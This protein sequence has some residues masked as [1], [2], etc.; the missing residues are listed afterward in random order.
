[1]YE[2]RLRESL[3]RVEERISAALQRTGR[4]G[5]VRVVAVTK[6][7]PVAAVLAAVQAGIT[8][9]AENRVQE[10]E[11]K[12]SVWPDGVAGPAWHLI[13]HLQRN[14][15]R[16]ALELFDWLHSI[17]SLRLAQELSKQAVRMGITA[18]VLVQVNVSGEQTKGGFDAARLLEHV[19]ELTQLPGLAVHGL[20][21]MAP[22][23]ADEALIRRTFAQTRSLLARCVEQGVPLHGSEL[24]MGMSGDFEIGIEEGST[25]VRLG[26]ILFGE[27]Q[28]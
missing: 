5:P 21:T 8:D 2:D 7:H 13:G 22:F 16:R 25:M 1:M 17:D 3:P 11:E 18:R 27:R 4:P 12:R 6:T 10:L 23:T 28:T 19:A 26:T 20:M 14:K 15:A 9:V 24:S